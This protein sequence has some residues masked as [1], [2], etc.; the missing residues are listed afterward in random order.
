M[1]EEKAMPDE[2]RNCNCAGP[3]QGGRDENEK[4]VKRMISLNQQVTDNAIWQ[5][6]CVEEEMI[7]RSRK[8]IM[9]G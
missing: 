3:G 1:T 5:S 2:S 4:S 8:S 9:I 6:Q 7:S